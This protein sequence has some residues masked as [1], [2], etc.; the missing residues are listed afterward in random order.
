MRKIALAGVAVL[1][2]A[3][4][5]NGVASAAD[6]GVRGH[7]SGAVMTPAAW[8]GGYW[9]PRFHGGFWGPRIGF[10]VYAP[11]WGPPPVYYAPP[12]VVVQQGYVAPPAAYAPQPGYA[13]QSDNAGYW[14]YCND[15]QGYYPYVRQ[16]TG[17]WQTVP[18]TP[19]AGQAPQ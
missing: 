6:A 3:T 1:I 16:C 14:Y 4:G 5:I 18:A 10:G 8:R 15:P 13:P 17:Q 2:A 9:G 19:D 7:S 12:P 11:F